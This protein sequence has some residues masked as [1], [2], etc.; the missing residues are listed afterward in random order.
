ME[1]SSQRILSNGFLMQFGRTVGRFL[2]LNKRPAVAKD[3]NRKEAAL[4]KRNFPSIRVGGGIEWSQLTLF[5]YI[6]WGEGS[7]W[8]IDI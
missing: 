7:R 8:P 6:N 1:G 2:S 3:K 5:C 4:C